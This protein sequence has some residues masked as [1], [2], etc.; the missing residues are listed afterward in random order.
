MF[1]ELEKAKFGPEKDRWWIPGFQDPKTTWN[2]FKT[3]ENVTTPQ[4]APLHGLP[5][6]WATKCYKTGGKT[7]KD[8]WYLFRAPTTPPPPRPL[9]RQK[10][11]PFLWKCFWRWRSEGDAGKGTGQKMSWQSVPLM[12]IG[13]VL[14]A[15]YLPNQFP[16]FCTSEDIHGRGGVG[17]LWQNGVG[18]EGDRFVFWRFSS[19]PL[20]GVPFCQKF[21]EI[22]H[23]KRGI[24]TVFAWNCPKLTFEFGDKFA[25]ILRTLPL[26]YET[27]YTGNFAQ[28]WPICDKFAQN[29]RTPPSRGFSDFDLHRL[30]GLEEWEKLANMYMGLSGSESSDGDEARKHLIDSISALPLLNLGY[31]RHRVNVVGRWGGQ[32]AFNQIL[33]RFHGIRLKSG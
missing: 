23:W 27:K 26:M 21:G 20:F 19:R 6:N 13:F 17:G 22:R 25:T 16:Q 5:P 12:F 14:R 24:S 4:L 9:Y 18:G 28:I 29:S 7:Q 15:P 30:F 10:M 1:W 31:S 3:R 11:A 32:T 2:A 8:K 33:T